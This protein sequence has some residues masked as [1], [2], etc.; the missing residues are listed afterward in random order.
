MR[1]GW[2]F[3]A[4]RFDEHPPLILGGVV[5]S[6]ERGVA[7]TSD[8]DL[9]VHAVIDALLGAAAIGD[10]GTFFPSSD[11]RWRGADSFDLLAH[12][13]TEVGSAGWR[14]TFVD[15]TIVAETLRISGFRAAIQ[16]NLAAGLSLDTTE[17]S[18][19][20]TT[21][22]GLGFIGRDQGIAVTAAVTVASS[23]G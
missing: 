10:L 1:V 23:L 9:V 8:G 4:H 19:K 18:V 14:A 5:V 2:G 12:T 16:S 6:N 17:V 20:A 3:D 22:D 11:P 13:L 15:V 21:T 7:A